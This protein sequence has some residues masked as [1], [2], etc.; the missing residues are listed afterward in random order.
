M[1]IFLTFQ[2]LVNRVPGPI[3]DPS[4]IVTSSIN[5]AQLQRVATL[6][7]PPL[8][9]PEL[10]EPLP[11]MAVGIIAVGGIAV[12]GRGVIVGEGVGLNIE[13]GVFVG[14]FWLVG[15]GVNSGNISAGGAVE[16]GT[17]NTGISG[18]STTGSV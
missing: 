7:A 12:V 8:D 1:P 13:S 18:T 14:M 9:P 4:G 2:I 3:T 16:V 11:V 5:C 17:I 10:P 15:V 6:V